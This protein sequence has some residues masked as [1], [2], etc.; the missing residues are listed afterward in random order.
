[1]SLIYCFSCLYRAYSFFINSI[2]R[3]NEYNRM[4]AISAEIDL[5]SHGIDYLKYL[6]YADVSEYIPEISKGKVVKVHSDRTIS[7][8]TAL[9]SDISMPLTVYRFTVWLFDRNM[10][11]LTSDSTEDRG[12]AEKMRNILSARILGKI[13]DLKNLTIENQGRIV[14]DVF[15]EDEYVNKW[16]METIDIIKLNKT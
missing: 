1:M 10:Q 12:E 3:K 7:V 6:E 9:D 5:T 16:I 14:A 2:A 13:V 4:D 8:I 15:C 11:E